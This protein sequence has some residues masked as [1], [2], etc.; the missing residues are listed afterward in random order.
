MLIRTDPIRTVWW[1]LLL[2]YPLN[3][4]NTTWTSGQNLIRCT[5]P[6]RQCLQLHAADSLS[7]YKLT[8]FDA[9]LPW[10]CLCPKPILWVSEEIAQYRKL[11]IHKHWMCCHHMS[12]TQNRVLWC[13]N[14]AVSSQV[15]SFWYLSYC[16][17]FIIYCCMACS[18]VSCP[19]SWDS[20]SITGMC[21][22]WCVL[23]MA[24]HY[25]TNELHLLSTIVT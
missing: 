7:G 17:L 23:H 1:Q 4:S 18:T 21:H 2:G 10:Y 13:S 6:A 19:I 3:L 5:C 15:V 14:K 24:I 20:R 22:F 11:H 12:Y 9:A 25:Y 8:L 16:T